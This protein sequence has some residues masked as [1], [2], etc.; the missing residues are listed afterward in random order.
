MKSGMIEHRV[1]TYDAGDR[2]YWECSCGSAGSV[3]EWGNVDLAS[4]KHIKYENGDT[5]IDVRRVIQ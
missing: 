5:R 3:G 2:Q 1:I 4:D